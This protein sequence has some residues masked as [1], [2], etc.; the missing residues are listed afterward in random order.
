M[1]RVVE[2]RAWLQ[3]RQRRAEREQWA[4]CLEIV[5]QSLA[6]A[7]AALPEAEPHEARFLRRRASLLAELLEYAERHT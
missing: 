2:L 1:G 7:E 3:A 6:E 4:R 5:A